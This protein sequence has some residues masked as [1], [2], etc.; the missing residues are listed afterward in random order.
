MIVAT[1]ADMDMSRDG[2]VDPGADQFPG[3]FVVTVN[4]QLGKH[5]CFL[6]QHVPEVLQF[7]GILSL[8][9]TSFL[10]M[11]PAANHNTLIPMVFKSQTKNAGAH[12]FFKLEEYLKLLD[13]AGVIGHM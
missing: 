4:T 8:T 12:P 2:V 13:N 5:P 6:I 7:H 3:N 11:V 10:K 1:E 9:V